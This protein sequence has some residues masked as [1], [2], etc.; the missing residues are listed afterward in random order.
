VTKV[1]IDVSKHYVLLMRAHLGWVDRRSN[2][3]RNN[4]LQPE[5]ICARFGCNT[6]SDEA[7]SL[8][9]K[10][11]RRS[12]SQNIFFCYSLPMRNQ[13]LIVYETSKK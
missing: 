4:V 3:G 6:I 11:G 12:V 8:D 10:A 13:G 1:L 7:A 9:Q 5:I 2:T